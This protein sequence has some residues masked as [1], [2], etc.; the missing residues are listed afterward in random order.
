MYLNNK[1]KNIFGFCLFGFLSLVLLCC[2]DNKA[3]DAKT[4]V[5]ISDS[6]IKNMSIG[7]ARITQVRSELKLT[8]KVTA[9]QSK[10]LE[11]YPLV[12]GTVKTVNVELGDYVEKDQ[13]LAV[14]KSGDVAD[15]EKQLIEAKSDYE[16]SKKSLQ[17]AED[18]YA[19]KLVSERDYLS[20][21]QD[22]NKAEAALTKAKEVQKIYSVSSGSDYV[23][24]APISGFVIDKKINKDMQMRP[25]NTESLFIISQLTDVWVLANVYETDID[26]VKEKDTVGVTTIAYPN[27]V[28][29]ATID[30]VYNILDPQSRVMKIRVKLDNT[31]YALKPEMYAN[32]VVNYAEPLS[33]VTIA[34]TAIVFD[35]SNN[36]VLIYKGGKNFIVQKIDLYKTIGNKAYVRSGLSENARIVTGN[37]LLIY[38]ALTN[39]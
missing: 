7:T 6:L 2:T 29:K 28:Y 14:I 15:F 36:Y 16:V 20:A 24:K 32:V 37:Q 21:K 8:G 25:D 12:G 30:K 5:E 13:V 31:D 1:M 34:S 11:I 9:D 17:V 38:N 10:Q 26:K 39:N 18:M 23:I 22:F 35:N 27:K 4:E 3:K 33:M 19:S